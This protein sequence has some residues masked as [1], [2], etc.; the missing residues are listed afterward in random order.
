MTTAE[1]AANTP[2]TVPFKAEVKQLLNI[3]SAALYTD[4]EIFLRELISNSSDALRRVQFALLTDNTLSEPEAELEIRL[5]SDDSAHTI[6]LSDSGIGMTQDEMVTTLGTIA[7]SG[8]RAALEQLEKAQRSD[9]IGQFGVGFYSVFAV[10]DKVTVVSRSAQPDAQAAQWESTG[11]DAFTVASAEREHRGT[12]VTLHLKDDAHEFAQTWR[13]KQIIKKHSD[14]VAFPIMVGDEQANQKM[15]LWRRAPRDV[16]DEQYNDFYRQ[17]TFDF[18]PPLK[19]LHISTD[20]PLDLHAVLFIPATRERGLMERRTEG[21]IKLY[22]RNILIQEDAPDL[23][24]KHFRFIEGVVDSEDVPLNVSRETI[25]RGPQ[26]KIAKLLNGRL[27]RE[28]NDMAE[29]EPDSYAT[30]FREFG[31]FLKE[32]IAL[33]PQTKD[34]LVKLLRFNSTADETAVVSLAQYKER[35]IE[36]QNEIYYVLGNDL[37]SARRSP[38]LDP[39]YERKIEVLL[40]HDVMDSFMLNNLHDFDGLKLRNADDP[41]ITLPG[42][43][44]TED[45]T[46]LAADEFERL[47]VRFKDVLGERITEVRQSKVL[48]GSPARLVSPA[49][50]PNRNM[51]RVQRL[52]D[53][54]YS[55]PAKIIEL[56][57]SHP[58]LHSLASML[59]AHPDDALLPVI[60]EQIYANAL[61]LEGLHPNPAD[62]VPHIQQLMEAAVKRQG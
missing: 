61:V 49:D 11:D 21:K 17:L 50:A 41:D 9:I 29:E 24:P 51:E 45:A 36:G 55:V 47:A 38:H 60:I 6:T 58:L 4:R 13:L 15:A 8:A 7:Q 62:M 32:G 34:D 43:D 37:P 2:A 28:L 57:A 39:F 16:T 18:Q 5:S 53:R 1:H 42:S 33:D 23:L 44:T 3:L 19:R 46:P 26:Q 59:V 20:V 48:K 14:F 30:F 54:D 25:Q 12:T 35:L 27:V 22:S 52:M 10:A 56:N 31:P 40:F